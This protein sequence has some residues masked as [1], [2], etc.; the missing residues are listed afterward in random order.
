VAAA[1]GGGGPG[2]RPKAGLVPPP[3]TLIAGCEGV[4]VDLVGAL[5]EVLVGRWR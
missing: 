5:L 1:N 2:S 4:V 3:G